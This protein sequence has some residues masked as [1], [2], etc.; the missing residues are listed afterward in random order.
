MKDTTYLE[1][2][3]LALKH[4]KK[5][6]CDFKGKSMAPALKDGMK[7]MVGNIAPEEIR[8][9]DIILYRQNAALIIHRVIKIL[10]EGGGKRTFITKGDNHAYMDAAYIPEE[11][12]LGKITGAFFEDNMDVNLLIES[13]FIEIL[14][15]IMGNI[16]L[17]LRN[18]RRSVPSFIRAIF[19]KIVGGFFIILKSLIHFIYIRIQNGQMLSRRP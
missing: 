18:N 9:G 16:A 3:E 13:R 4:N 11:D 14:Y 2:V 7:A 5:T 8:N 1:L 6:L 12:L 15:V 19:K 10:K 17:L